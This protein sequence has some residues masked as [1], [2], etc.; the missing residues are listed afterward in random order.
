MTAGIANVSARVLALPQN[1]IRVLILAVVAIFMCGLFNVTPTPEQ[2][3]AQEREVREWPQVIQSRYDLAALTSFLKKTVA[4]KKCWKDVDLTKPKIGDKWTINSASMSMTSGNWEFRT[5]DPKE[6]KFTLSFCYHA[7]EKRG[8]DLVLNCIRKSKDS[9]E[10]IEI[11]NDEW[12][13][14]QF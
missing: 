10:L 14:V 5:R 9:F 13:I 11:A 6:D 1:M 12:E 8:L 3:E 7:E 4:E 2:R